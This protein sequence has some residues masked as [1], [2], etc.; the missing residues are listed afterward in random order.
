MAGDAVLTRDGPVGVPL[1]YVVPQSGEL[2]PLTV[3]ATIDG[4]GAAVAFYA[5][6]QVL[7]PSG[8]IMGS[9]ISSAIAAGGSADVTWFPH[10]GGQTG[11]VTPTGTV[12]WASLFDN[13]IPVPAGSTFTQY[14]FTAAGFYTNDSAT[15]TVDATNGLTLNSVGWYAFGYTL[16]W[17]IDGATTAGYVQSQLNIP[18]IGGHSSTPHVLYVPGGGGTYYA[19]TLEAWGFPMKS[20]TVGSHG[21]LFLRQFSDVDAIVQM[22]FGISLLSASHGN[23]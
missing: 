6:V 10:V 4:S 12:S 14:D 13:N 23:F 2:L 7:A 18:N 19:T 9:Y 20:S 1:D 22:S 16:N 3:R 8:R 11:G 15:F 5:T 21:K 17:E